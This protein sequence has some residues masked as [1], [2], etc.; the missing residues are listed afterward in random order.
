M[1]IDP[2]TLAIIA[3]GIKLGSHAIGAYKENKLNKKKNKEMQRQNDEDVLNSLRNKSYENEEQGAKS[4]QKLSKRR[5]ES[6]RN[7]AASVR[8]SL[9]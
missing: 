1:V 7:T 5:S 2:V 9:R 4:S 3:A 6:L 8:G